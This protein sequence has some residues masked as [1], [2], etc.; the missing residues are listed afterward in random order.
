MSAT[1]DG[2]EWG[3]DLEDLK[4]DKPALPKFRIGEKVFMRSNP[5]LRGVVVALFPVVGDNET[6]DV[7]WEGSAVRESM[8]VGDLRSEERP[9]A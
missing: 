4:L 5:D 8:W 9:E 7:M 1:D 6:I 3:E 2:L